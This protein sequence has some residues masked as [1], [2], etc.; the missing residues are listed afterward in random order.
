MLLLTWLHFLL[1]CLVI[2]QTLLYL[3]LTLLILDLPWLD[4]EMNL[5]LVYIN[6][7]LLQIETK[8]P[9]IFDQGI[10][11]QHH[12]LYN[13]YYLKYNLKPNFWN[14]FSHKR[15]CDK[16]SH[17]DYSKH[18]TKLGRSSSSFFGRHWVKRGLQSIFITIFNALI[19]SSRHL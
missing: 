1:T 10:L 5:T 2:C 16:D 4:R 14:K 7:K 18:R 15:T 12:C 9:A 17:M 13:V 6:V 11:I 19:F 8:F 3:S